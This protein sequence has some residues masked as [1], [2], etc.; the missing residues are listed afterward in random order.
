MSVQNHLLLLSHAGNFQGQRLLIL[1]FSVHSNRDGAQAKCLAKVPIYKNSN[2]CLNDQG[3]LQLI[4][5]YLFA[6]TLLAEF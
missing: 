5:L 2:M 1:G 6:D 4:A 3:F